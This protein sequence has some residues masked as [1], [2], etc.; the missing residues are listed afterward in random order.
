MRAGAQIVSLATKALLAQSVQ[1]LMLMVIVSLAVA[2]SILT[3]GIIRAGAAEIERLSYGNFGR[4]L[5]LTDNF[6]IQ[7]PFGAPTLSEQ[8]AI[9]NHLGGELESSS[10]WRTMNLSVR[11][12]ARDFIVPVH[13]V[14]GPVDEQLELDLE[15][16]RWLPADTLIPS[17]QC[18]LG[19]NAASRTLSSDRQLPTFIQLNGVNCEVIGVLQPGETRVSAAYDSAIF[20]GLN[21]ANAYFFDEGDMGAEE[22]D[23]LLFLLSDGA[24]PEEYIAS[25]DRIVRQLRGVSQRH[26][27]PVSYEEAG[28]SLRSLVR[29]RQLVNRTLLSLTAITVSVAFLGYGFAS[30][31]IA[32]GRRSDVAIMLACG[33]SSARVLGQFLCEASMLGILGGMLGVTI[34]YVAAIGLGEF[35]YVP[36]D[37]RLMD[38]VYAPLIGLGVG[39]TACSLGAVIVSTADPADALRAI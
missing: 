30:L 35:A 38:I 21:A 24:D 33:A 11:G 25:V 36:A 13:G 17:R 14:V 5:V 26:P 12:V 8:Q 2:A 37:I 28:A 39:V 29:Q 7:H 20:V 22:V 15:R 9:S 23:Q 27:S 31:M 6:Q 16:G 34:A 19:A 3:L 18:V 32:R 1:S 4:S 10:A